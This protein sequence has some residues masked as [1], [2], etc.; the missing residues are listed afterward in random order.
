[1]N[2]SV[3]GECHN[4][5]S[6]YDVVYM[7]ELTSEDYPQFCPFCGETIEELT[8]SDYIE[9]EDDLDNEEWDN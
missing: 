6:S 9:D 2:K 3:T 1:M 7:E 5:E 4:C 8:E